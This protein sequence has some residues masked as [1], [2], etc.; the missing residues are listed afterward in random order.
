VAAAGAAG[1]EPIDRAARA[2]G[3]NGHRD[4]ALGWRRRG[5]VA[6]AR[7]DATQAVISTPR[8]KA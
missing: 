8:Q 6:P 3:G 4:G 1:A 7:R 2:L 5:P